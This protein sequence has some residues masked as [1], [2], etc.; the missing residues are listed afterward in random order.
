MK[1]I[2]YAEKKLEINKQID[3]KPIFKFDE[4]GYLVFAAFNIIWDKVEEYPNIEIYE[5]AMLK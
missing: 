3:C 1:R 4:D 2:F 5:N